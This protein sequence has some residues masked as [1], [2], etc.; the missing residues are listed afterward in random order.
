M[1]IYLLTFSA[2]AAIFVYTRKTSGRV[3]GRYTF[4]SF[5]IIR[6]YKNKSI[7]IKYTVTVV[8]YTDMMCTK[9]IRGNSTRIKFLC[10]ECFKYSKCSA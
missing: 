5:T 2:I 8:L 10:G 4:I 6:L 9:K 1:R 3:S 7:L